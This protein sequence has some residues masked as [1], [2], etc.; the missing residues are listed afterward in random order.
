MYVVDIAAAAGQ[1][2][3]I[4]ASWERLTHVHGHGASRMARPEGTMKR[5]DRIDDADN[6]HATATART[7]FPP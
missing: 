3:R 2:P 1:E 5:P 6:R 4:L 7:R